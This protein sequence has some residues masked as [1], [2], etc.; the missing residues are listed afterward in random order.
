[1]YS[2][3]ERVVIREHYFS[4]K[5]FAA[6]REASSNAY[7]DKEVPNKI[8]IYRMLTKVWDTGNVCL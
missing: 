2:G 4:S 3:V 8:T 5:L 6:V 1:M 7:P